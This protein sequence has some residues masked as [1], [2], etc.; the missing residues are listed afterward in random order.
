MKRTMLS[1][2]ACCV[3][4]GAFACAEGT[5]PEEIE[6]MPWEDFLAMSTQHFDGTEYYVVDGDIAVAK[7]EVRPYYD[8]LVA[9]IRKYNQ[10]LRDGV[11]SVSLESTVNRFGGADDIWPASV[12]NNLTY[13]VSNEFGGDK[14]LIR[15]AMA[16]ATADLEAHGNFDFRYISSADSN[17]NNGNSS[18][19]FSVRPTTGGGACAFFPSGGGCVPRTII[20]NV[21]EFGGTISHRGV[22]RHELGHVLGLRHEHI[23]VPGTSC[24]EGTQWRAVTAYDSNS[25]MHYPSCQGSTNTGD[26]VVTALDGQGINALYGGGGGADPNSCIESN[27]CG[28][29]APG[30][31]W[32][33]SQC[34]SFGDCCSDGPC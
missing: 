7:E 24:S 9:S 17:C 13:C 34:T 3:V 15:N 2:L 26:L 8:R 5:H 23:R 14:T 31:C 12:R 11:S 27:A 16:G 30:G 29:Q 6:I 4:V 19:L 33:D 1:M 25:M 18:V 21:S 10:S 28:S 32:C 22:L 20:I